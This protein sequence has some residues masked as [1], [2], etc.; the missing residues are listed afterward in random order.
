M[1]CLFIALYYIKSIAT[2]GAAVSQ[3]GRT[4]GFDLSWNRFQ[5][6]RNDRTKRDFVTYGTAAGIAAM[7]RSPIGG[8]LF[9]LEVQAFINAVL[10]LL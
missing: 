1:Y 8:V 5:D 4:L 9:A 2:L 7:F 6:F 10:I 3:G